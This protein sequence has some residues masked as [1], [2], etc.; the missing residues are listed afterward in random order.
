MGYLLGRFSYAVKRT[1]FDST[2]QE[3][4][5][6]RLDHQ[7]NPF[8]WTGSTSLKAAVRNRYAL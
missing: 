1:S 5:G 3:I 6:G 8:V 4:N 7:E 2:D